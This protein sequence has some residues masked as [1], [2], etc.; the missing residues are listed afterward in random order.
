MATRLGQNTGMVFNGCN[1]D[2]WKM[3]FYSLNARVELAV[4]AGVD[5]LY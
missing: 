1:Y 5:L 4:L 2:V 3:Q